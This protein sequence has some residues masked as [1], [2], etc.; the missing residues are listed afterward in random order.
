MTIDKWIQYL[1]VTSAWYVIKIIEWPTL[2]MCTLAEAQCVIVI[3]NLHVK[4]LNF[5]RWQ[6]CMQKN[7]R[8]MST[9][10]ECGTWQI[11]RVCSQQRFRKHG[12][13]VT[14]GTLDWLKIAERFIRTK[15]ILRDIT[16]DVLNSLLYISEK[17]S[18]IYKRYHNTPSSSFIIIIIIIIIVI[19]TV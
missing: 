3:F 15:F 12:L 7:D 16:P 17:I 11:V 1:L 8:R 14:I 10:H 18:K 19:K 4:Q 6:Y 2:W 13:N 9:A 5:S